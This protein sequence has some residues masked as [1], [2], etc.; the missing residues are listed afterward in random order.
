MRER[1]PHTISALPSLFLIMTLQICVCLVFDRT[2]H[3]VTFFDSCSVFTELPK[4][5]FSRILNSNMPKRKYKSD[6]LRFGF[7]SVLDKS[8]TE[9]PQCVLCLEILSNE[10]LKK[11]KLTKH[12]QLKHPEASKEGAALFRK[13]GQC[14]E[15]K[16]RFS[17]ESVF[18]KVQEGGDGFL[19]DFAANRP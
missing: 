6:F 5:T 3:K 10:A 14:E 9:W 15:A 8:G 1:Q 7:T 4:V 12:L 13:K 19:P 11:S 18:P 2:L 16:A 17:A